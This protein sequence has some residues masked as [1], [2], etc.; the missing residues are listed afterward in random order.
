[1][2]HP[3]QSNVLEPGRLTTSPSIFQDFKRN[4]FCTCDV[5]SIVDSV[6]STCNHIRSACIP[7]LAYHYTSLIPDDTW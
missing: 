5:C 3:N 7:Q 4:T 1:M 6:P 2:L